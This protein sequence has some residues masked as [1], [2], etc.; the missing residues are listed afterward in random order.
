MSIVRVFCGFPGYQECVY[1]LRMPGEE[2]LIG[3]GICN[4]QDIQNLCNIPAIY[5]VLCLLPDSI[6]GINTDVNTGFMHDIEIVPVVH[7]DD[8]VFPC[9][10]VFV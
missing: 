6:M 10:A 7:E 2:C 5:Q 1:C 8:C 9:E 3:I 4:V